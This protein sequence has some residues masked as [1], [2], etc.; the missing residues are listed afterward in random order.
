M[1]DTGS[2]HLFKATSLDQ[3][4]DPLEMRNHVIRKSLKLSADSG[5]EELD[6]PHTPLPM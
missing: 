1:F 6:G 2:T 3:P 5:V 4:D